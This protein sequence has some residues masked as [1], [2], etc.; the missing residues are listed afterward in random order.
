M[1]HSSPWR[2]EWRS[3]Y[4]AAD[5]SAE[6]RKVLTRGDAPLAQRRTHRALACESQVTR[7]G[8]QTVLAVHVDPEPHL[9]RV[10]VRG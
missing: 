9:V 7:R 2:S 3:S 5:A 4:S 10:R 8:R 1:F 6:L